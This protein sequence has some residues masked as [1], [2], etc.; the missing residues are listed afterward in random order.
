VNLRGIG[1]SAANITIRADNVLFVK[2]T[3]R[4]GSCSTSDRRVEQI[5]QHSDRDRWFTLE[6]MAYGPIDASITE[7]AEAGVPG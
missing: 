1:G 5:D 4:S 7:A 2:R 6:D 3:I